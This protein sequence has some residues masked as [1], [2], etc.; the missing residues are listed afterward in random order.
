MA[1]GK[2][3]T[4]EEIVTYK[5]MYLDTLRSTNGGCTF[6]ENE[7]TE[8]NVVDIDW[9]YYRSKWMK[10]DEYFKLQVETLKNNR[11]LVVEDIMFDKIRMERDT[12]LIK[13]VLE[14]KK[15]YKEETK[16]SIDINQPIKINII[17]PEDGD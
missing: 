8:R 9:S 16:Q 14:R 3:L 6:A 2:K 17:K 7:L 1:Q 15:G 5:A 13:F 10:I 4:K 11:L 12:A